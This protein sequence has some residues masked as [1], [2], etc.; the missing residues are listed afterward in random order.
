MSAYLD[1][2]V[3]G[4]SVALFILAALLLAAAFLDRKD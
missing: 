2:H 4:V 1:G 3:N